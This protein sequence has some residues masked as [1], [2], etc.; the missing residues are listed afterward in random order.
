VAAGGARR[1]PTRFMGFAL[2]LAVVAVVGGVVAATAGALAFDD[3][4]PC[5]AAY[6]EPV[7]EEPLPQPD[8][9]CP[10]GLVGTPYS[11]QLVARGSCEPFLRFTV[12]SGALPPGLSLSSRGLISGTPTT[13]GH[14]RFRVRAQDLRA[15]DG[16][17]DW[18][19]SSDQVDGDFVIGVDPGIVI[20]TESA[21]P[22]TVGAVYNLTLSARM[23]VAAN[24]L[25]TPSGCAPGAPVTSFCPLTW[26]IA[27]GQLPP[28]LT[29]NPVSGLIWGT[30][31]VEGSASFVVR[32]ALDDGRT[33]TKSLTITVRKPVSIDARKPVGAPGA[34]TRWE[35]GVPFAAKL[36]AT[37]GTNTYS[38]S[39]TAG[40]LP[41]GLSLADDGRIVGTPRTAGRFR[42]TIQVTDGEG[43]TAGRP[44]DFRVVPRLAIST[45]RLPPGRVGRPYR[46]T[47]ATS[48]GLA[49][50]RWRIADEALPRGLHFDRA[51]GALAGTPTRSGRYRIAFQATD[52][53]GA[54]ATRTLVIRVLP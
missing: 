5:P 30:P 11:V 19:T 23:M 38:W 13:S 17:P 40:A 12:V 3:A 26:S 15:A 42:A 22:G 33:A 21:G 24:Q 44:V 43:R 6:Q 36:S 31:N 47:L 50:K 2:A 52:A 28:R 49:P 41:R 4:A 48:G 32:A 7:G 46:A 34:P 9:L 37:G 35:V 16:G 53:I 14:W 1:H 29:L 27:Q 10:R 39:L 25:T 18:C 51:R 54:T 8:F 20:T 45:H